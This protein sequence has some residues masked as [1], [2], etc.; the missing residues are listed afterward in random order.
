M[1]ILAILILITSLA[2][3]GIAA[4]F[5]VVGLAL[6]FVGSGQSIIVMG[7]ALEVGKL[8]VV[9]FLHQ[10]W[11]R[12]NFLIKTYLIIAT[13]L[14]MAI[15]S[16]GIYGYLSS[17]YNTTSNKV[18]EIERQIIFNEKQI[19][20]YRS[21]ILKFSNFEYKSDNDLI[22]TNKD[23]F[24]AQQV[25][26]I[27][28]KEERIN[29]SRIT[30]EQEKKKIIEEQNNAKILL[31]GEINKE[32]EQIK[33][34]NDRLA[35]LDKEVQTWLD[36]GTGGLF[37]ANG[38]E[39]ARQVKQLQEKERNQ[40][41]EQIKNKQV[42]IEKL[43]AEY[44]SRISDLSKTS[45]KITN[46]LSDTIKQIE[47]DITKSKQAI[48]EYQLKT[49]KLLAEQVTIKDLKQRE[50]AVKIKQDEAEIEKLLS[51]NNTLQG[52]ILNTDIGTFK[53]V[54]KS[55]N[56]ELDQ[57]VNWFIWII[58]LV[59]DPL[60]VS[61]V[62][63]FNYILKQRKPKEITPVATKATIITNTPTITP[64]PNYTFVSIPEITSTT[65]PMTSTEVIS[66]IKKVKQPPPKEGE[67]ARLEKILEEQRKERAERKHE[68]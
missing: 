64:T 57:A 12:L 63:C 35:I 32:I 54:A 58:M 44:N 33:L 1:L 59:F 68:N 23:K 17:G 36:Q 37:K 47:L 26:L 7:T 6:L 60:A 30:A 5:S 42:N 31:D 66:G 24:V 15:T 3:A 62:I 38:I 53:F 11:E 19:A 25:E 28:Q 29:A 4:Y 51:S 14:L 18:K 50:V 20:Q 2:I 56:T 34:Y 43:R 10:Y 67:V 48:E 46:T 8:V 49:D 13:I 40:I 55:L 27:K 52:Q 41:D 21:D 39:K 45:E 22:I 61:L 65:M 16:I 9:S